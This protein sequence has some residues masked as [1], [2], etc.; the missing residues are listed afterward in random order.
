[1]TDQVVGAGAHATAATSNSTVAA[2]QGER[3]EAA[4]AAVAGEQQAGPA[5]TGVASSDIL[6]ETKATPVSSASTSATP[7]TAGN[8]A[9]AATA[10]PAAAKATAGL[11]KSS[12]SSMLPGLTLPQ[13]MNI[14]RDDVIKFLKSHS[15]YDFMPESGKVVVLD[16]RIS[17]KLAFFALVEHELT[18]APLWDE[19][20]H[21]HVGMLTS[22]DLIQILEYGYMHNCVS[23]MF[24]MTVGQWL[25]LNAALRGSTRSRAGTDHGEASGTAGAVAAAELHASNGV[26]ANVSA[27]QSEDAASDA[28][29]GSMQAEGHGRALASTVPTP[30]G[31]APSR[32]ECMKLSATRSLYDAVRILH[33]NRKQRVSI[34]DQD[35]TSTLLQV[36]TNH[37]L[38]LYLVKTF[39]RHVRS[40]LL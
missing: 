34:I 28:G 8:P 39:T 26:D 2:A 33:A 7:A 37:R 12:S 9:A 6:E 19:V 1:M 18:Y 4:A 29:Q 20:R 23:Q 40:V 17:V 5:L 13:R 31:C 15:C 10:G 27:D 38:L 35:D 24:A 36:L 16:V 32:H 3:R 25:E 11:P 30:A 22:T 14:D 21:N